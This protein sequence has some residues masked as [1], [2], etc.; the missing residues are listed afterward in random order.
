M[1][2][3]RRPWWGWRQEG[4]G[5]SSWWPV[6]KLLTKQATQDDRLQLQHCLSQ[7]VTS[8]TQSPIFRPDDSALENLHFAHLKGFSLWMRRCFIRSPTWLK[9]LLKRCVFSPLWMKRCWASCA[10]EWVLSVFWHACQ[11]QISLAAFEP[12]SPRVSFQ[13]SSQIACQNRCKVALV[14]LVR[15]FSGVNFQMLSNYPSE[16]MHC[17]IGCI[18]TTF[19][20]SE[21]SNI[22]SNCV[23]KQ[24]HSRIGSIWMTFVQCEFSNVFSNCLSE[25][26]RSRIGC[27]WTI[28]LQ[29]EFS[30]VFSDCLLKQMHS[31]IAYERL[32]SR[33]I[34]QMPGLQ[35]VLVTPEVFT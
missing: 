17:H 33:V 22:F 19:F 5:R 12:L 14:A 24:M 28:F 31:A 20:Q 27:I 18:F 10:Q 3:R 6:I 26:M 32:F 21:F 34:F 2:G 30:N 8:N 29:S 7:G 25:Q 35:I 23:P 9:E 4:A 11:K 1:L 15:L 16:Q 13:M